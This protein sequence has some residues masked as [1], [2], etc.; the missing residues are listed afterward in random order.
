MKWIKGIMITNINN[1]NTNMKLVDRIIMKTPRWSVY[2]IMALIIATLL[3]VYT[4]FIFG[5]E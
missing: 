5:A 4:W 3:C 2:V 1:T